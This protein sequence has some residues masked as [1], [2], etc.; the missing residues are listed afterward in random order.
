MSVHSGP[1]TGKIVAHEDSCHDWCPTCN[2]YMV[3][4]IARL[5]G[6]TGHIDQVCTGCHTVTLCSVKGIEQR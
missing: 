5:D 1:V 4:I 3:Q 2:D 6:P